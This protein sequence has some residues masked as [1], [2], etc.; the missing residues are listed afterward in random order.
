MHIT[1]PKMKFLSSVGTR[2]KGMQN[3]ASNRSL[4]L[5]LSK[6]TLVTVLILLFCIKVRITNVFP[7]TESRNIMVYNGILT[8]PPKSGAREGREF[9]LFSTTLVSL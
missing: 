9:V 1:S 3:T 8:S 2:V 7:T 6:N 4:I 5:K